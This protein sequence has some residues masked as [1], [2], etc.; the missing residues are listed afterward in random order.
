[1][2]NAA[3]NFAFAAIASPQVAGVPFT[4]TIRATDQSGNTVYDYAG[5]ALLSPIRARTS[6]PTLI[7]FVAGVER[8]GPAVSRRFLRAAHAPTSSPPRQGTSGNITVNPAS[9]VKLQVI[10]PGET[11]KGGTADGRTARRTI[12]MAGN[13]RSRSRCAPSTRTGTS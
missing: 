12:R 7:T 1:M 8:L 10:L 5:D 2:P 3:D 9:F 13:R 4:V 11:P 6:T